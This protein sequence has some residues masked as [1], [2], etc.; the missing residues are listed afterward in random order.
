ML[1]DLSRFRGGT[2][3]LERGFEPSALARDDDDFQIVS[4]VELVVS[5]HKDATKVRLAGTVKATLQLECSRCLDSFLV[6]VH[7]KVDTL[8]LPLVENTGEGEREVKEDD[9][10]VAYYQDDVIDLA[11]VMRE[12]FYLAL[13]MKP[14]CREDCRGLCPICGKNRNRETCA[15][16]HEWVDPRL[17]PLRKLR[18]SS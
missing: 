1:W 7:A 5:V 14:L 18:D 2:E 6:P 12:Q 17:E 13:P 9:L 11:E 15:C 4:P 10:G 16:Q 3:H 8:F